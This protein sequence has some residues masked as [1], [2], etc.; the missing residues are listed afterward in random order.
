MVSKIGMYSNEFV[1]DTRACMTHMMMNVSGCVSCLTVRVHVQWLFDESMT[2]SED[3]ETKICFLLTLI[4]ILICYIKMSV[5]A[6]CIH[7]KR[8]FVR[9][10]EKV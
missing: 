9:I 6:K 1:C 3:D 4:Q 8:I 10:V 2:D 5:A 7:T